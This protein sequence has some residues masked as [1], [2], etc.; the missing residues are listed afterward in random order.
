MSNGII[1][2]AYSIELYKRIEKDARTSADYRLLAE[3]IRKIGITHHH[4]INTLEFEMKERELSLLKKAESLAKTADDWLRLACSYYLRGANNKAENLGEAGFA[5][6]LQMQDEARVVELFAKIIDRFEFE[7][8]I[9]TFPDALGN[10][11]GVVLEDLHILL[12]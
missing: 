6:V 10:R 9:N 12:Q 8:G 11:F 5:L 7:H 2:K 3:S 1:E 4:R